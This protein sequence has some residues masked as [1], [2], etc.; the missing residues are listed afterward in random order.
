MG[1]EGNLTETWNVKYTHQ[2][3]TRA[4]LSARAAADRNR[5]QGF[6][7]FGEIVSCFNKNVNQEAGTKFSICQKRDDIKALCGFLLIP[8]ERFH[9]EGKE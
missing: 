2:V 4:E 8:Q 1:W 6:S 9:G 3:L 7:A 5:T